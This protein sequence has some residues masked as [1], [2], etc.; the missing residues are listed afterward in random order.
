M[1]NSYYQTP[2]TP[3][4]YVS[5]PLWQYANGGLDF[6]MGYVNGAYGNIPDEDLIKAIQ[7]DCSDPVSL[8]WQS[9]SVAAF[10]Y[11]LVNS[12]NL[13]NE[14]PNNLWNFNYAMV[15]NHNLASASVRPYIRQDNLD[16][17]APYENNITQQS[18][19]NHANVPEYDG[20]SVW[21]L[22][23]GPINN[24][25]TVLKFAFW[26]PASLPPLI[27][28]VEI[29]TL[30]WGKYFDFPQP[31]DLNTTLSYQYGTRSVKNIGG[32]S[33]NTT[34]WTKTDGW[35]NSTTGGTEPFGLRGV[36]S[37]LNDTADSFRRKSGIRV[38]NISFDSVSPQYLMNQ[39]P[40]MNSNGW[41]EGF[42]NY[43]V[44]ADTTTSTYNID[45]GLD[46]YTDVVHKTNGGSIPMVLQINKDD[47]SPQNFAIVKMSSYK[48]TQK[49]P[50]LY[51]ISLTLE[52]QV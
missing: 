42:D 36:D 52:E 35:Y 40:M 18:I 26:N 24:T 10:N 37:D 49:L 29:G 47:P 13:E 17:S 23:D 34:K 41:D 30:M 9:G 43:S 33:I 19:I 39:N 6:Y 51:S 16:G 1:A 25:D 31:C 28:P 12:S 22:T 3:R 27:S 8:D 38:W 5:Y 46:F 2:T 4:L 21:D 14:L 50:N 11:G 32:K 7:L 45:N 48:I 20:F 44:D 15:L